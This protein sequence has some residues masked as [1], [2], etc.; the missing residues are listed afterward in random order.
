MP[1]SLV[2]K[3]SNGKVR[4]IKPL[5]SDNPR[6][7]YNFEDRRILTKATRW[8]KELN[9]AHDDLECNVIHYNIGL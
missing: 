1:Y 9:K 7:E 2:F 3:Y 8:A 4:E 6:S 5:C